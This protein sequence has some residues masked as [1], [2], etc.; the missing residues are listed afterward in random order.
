[1]RHQDVETF[2][3][4]LPAT[5]LSVQWGAQRVYKIGGK[6][7]A[8]LGP[9]TR[10]PHDLCFKAGQTSFFIL[11]HQPHI[12]PA[13]YLARAQWVMLER[14]DALCAKELKAYLVQAHALVAAKL[15]RNVRS[16]LGLERFIVS[17]KP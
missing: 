6:M 7:F 17:R 1:M 13:P 14:L 4:S 5:V 3:L 16:E 10:I 9:K 12:V 2:C 11:T 8:M 15:T